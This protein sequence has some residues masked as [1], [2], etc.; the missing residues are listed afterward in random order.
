MISRLKH[1]LIGF[2]K[3]AGIRVRILPDNTW[4]IALN[5]LEEKRGVITKVESIENASDFEEVFSLLSVEVPVFLVVDG[6][7]VLHKKLSSEQEGTIGELLRMVIPNANANDFFCQRYF[8]GDCHYVSVLRSDSLEKILDFFNDKGFYVVKL[9]LGPYALNGI[10][11]IWDQKELQYSI[12]NYLIS[13]VDN[14]IDEFSYGSKKGTLESTFKV[15]EEL[16]NDREAL[17]YAVGLS[18]FLGEIPGV[19]SELPRLEHDKKE[20]EARKIFHKMLK[21][22]LGVV[23]SVLLINTIVYLNLNGENQKL[24]ARLS[25][26]SNLLKKLEILKAD[27]K[28]K[29]EFLANIGWQGQKPLAVLADQLASTLP[30][31]I[32][33]D[34]LDIHPLSEMVLKKDKQYVFQ[35]EKIVV[36]GKCKNSIL[37]NNWLANIEKLSWVE[38]VKGQQYFYQEKENTGVFQFEIVIKE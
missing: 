22:V 16:I 31:G 8:I 29:K 15:G 24:T 27:V 35:N 7:G 36:K 33:L 32:F 11:S 13:V 25:G 3:V 9:V 38:K 21:G 26:K 30:S 10:F 5:I 20:W 28:R 1:K 2:K 17:A 23:L 6:K 18:G 37:L 4:A 34:E 12:D 14:Y 19:S